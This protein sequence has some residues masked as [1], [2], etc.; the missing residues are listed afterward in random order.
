MRA[1]YKARG[2]QR[3]SV[4]EREANLI[5]ILRRLQM[6]VSVASLLRWLAGSRRRSTDKGI[7]HCPALDVR[8]GRRREIGSA[9]GGIHW[10]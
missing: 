8:S 4:R 6:T 5:S 1:A 9:K 2:A 10:R 3:V 7:V